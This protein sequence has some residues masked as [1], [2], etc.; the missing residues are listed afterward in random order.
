MMYTVE[1]LRRELADET[2]DLAPRVTF[3]QVRTRAV[4]RRLRNVIGTVAATL[5]PVFAVGTFVAVQPAGPSPSPLPTGLGATT[6]VPMV[7]H[8]SVGPPSE[9]LI[10]TGLSV[11]TGEQ[12]V[13]FYRDTMNGV[14]AGLS[15]PNNGR[16][17]ELDGGAAVKPGAF[18]TVFELDDRRGGIIDYGVF[19]RADARIEVTIGGK[20]RP[21]ST[22]RLPQLPDATLFWV[23]RDGVRAAPTGAA[24]APTPDA[25]F[26][27]R[28]A[29]GSVLGTAA[30]I[31]RS[32]GSLNRADS[33]ARIGEWMR[34]GLTLAAGGELVFWFDGDQN[35]AILHAGRDDGAGTVKELTAL[36]TYH[37]PPFDIGFY[38]GVHTFELL[39][40]MTVTVGT[41][42]GPAATVTMQGANA[43][44]PGSAR[45]SAHPQ[46]CIFW[47]VGVTGP[48]TGVSKDAQGNVVGATDFSKPG[49]G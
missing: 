6:I 35:S 38:A 30:R 5:V 8:P 49:G 18:G 10:S 7:P 14:E 39:D 31:Q 46:T 41:Y 15:D 43:S 25:V 3:E 45:W 19:G 21:A 28:D 20:S 32:D 37:R 11:G 13:L 22:G 2:R 42:V 16:L 26:T 29:A 27:A 12:L 33:A 44:R 48:P 1:D 23:K 4:R 17:R 24:G 40:G 9:P 34:T 36:G 47:A